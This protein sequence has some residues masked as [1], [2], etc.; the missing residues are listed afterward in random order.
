MLTKLFELII[1]VRSICFDLSCLIFTP[2]RATY[3]PMKS[4]LNAS[5]EAQRDSLTLA[6]RDRKLAE[7]S[8][9]GITVSLNFLFFLSS[10]H[11][12]AASR[13]RLI[14]I[15]NYTLCLELAD[16]LL[17]EICLIS[18]LLRG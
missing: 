9:V 15:H 17:F 5:T 11:S 1:K 7:L 3:E 14:I 13:S 10:S 8:F 2:W 4:L 12:V 18:R 16:H 6:W